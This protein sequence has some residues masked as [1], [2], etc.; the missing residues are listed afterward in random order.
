MNAAKATKRL[1]EAMN[2]SVTAVINGH[3]SSF[4]GMMGLG[5]SEPILSDFGTR[6]ISRLSEGGKTVDEV[7]WTIIPTAAAAAATQAQ[8]VCALFILHRHQITDNK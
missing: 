3:L 2:T 8:G 1:G 5:S 7:V 6:L 4:K